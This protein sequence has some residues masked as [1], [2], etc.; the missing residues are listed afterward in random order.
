MNVTMVASICIVSMLTVVHTNT[1]MVTNI[2]P[3]ILVTKITKV[4]VTFAT[5]VTSVGWL[6]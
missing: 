6:L 1:V 3:G 2:V 5:K 4:E